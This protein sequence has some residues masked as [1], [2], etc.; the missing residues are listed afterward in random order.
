MVYEHI[1]DYQK[2]LKFVDKLID[3]TRSGKL[4]WHV[5]A[6]PGD[7]ANEII[8]PVFI[9][10]IVGD[11]FIAIYRYKYPYYVGPEEYELREEVNIEL[12]DSLGRK[13][14]LLPQVK[15]RFELLDLINYKLA[16]ADATLEEFLND[17]L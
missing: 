9:T 15:P 17:K 11:R 10:E 1:D 16:G 6:D 5:I 7:R 2:W 14:W 4:E 8:S 3:D 12:V 13:Q